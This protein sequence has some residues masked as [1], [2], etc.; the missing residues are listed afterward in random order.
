MGPENRSARNG[1]DKVYLCTAEE[2]ERKKKI[3]HFDLMHW[4]DG[5]ASYD[6]SSMKNILTH[7]KMHLLLGFVHCI[8]KC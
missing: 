5:D 6:N 2:G 1:G 3:N 7:K 4:V 8:S